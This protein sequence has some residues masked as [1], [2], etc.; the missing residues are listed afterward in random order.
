MKNE[1]KNEDIHHLRKNEDIH[2]LRRRGEERGH[3]PLKEKNEERTK[4][5]TT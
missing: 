3:P 2:H 1:E 5:S 4:T